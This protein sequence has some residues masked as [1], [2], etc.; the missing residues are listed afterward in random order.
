MLQHFE[1]ELQL[2]ILC[3]TTANYVY[4]LDVKTEPKLLYVG[5]CSVCVCVCVCVCVYIYE[6]I[7]F[8]QPI[9]FL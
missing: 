8:F 9:F 4:K 2:N 1:C 5:I 6:K 7:N 3:N